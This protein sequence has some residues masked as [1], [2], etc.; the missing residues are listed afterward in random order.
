MQL[1]L[2]PARGGGVRGGR[3]GRTPAEG[4]RQ[5]SNALQRDSPPPPEPR[6]SAPSWQE[7]KLEALESITDNNT[8][9]LQKLESYIQENVCVA[10]EQLQKKT[11]HTQ[12]AAMLEISTNL[13]SHSTEQSR[14][15][16]DVETQVLNHTSRLEVQLLEYSLST[17]RLEKLFL[18]QANELA[19][20]NDRNRLLEQ[21]LAVMEAGHAEELRVAQQEKRQLQA[22]LDKHS[23]LDM[24]VVPRDEPLVSRD[25]AEIYK[26]GV[27]QSGVYTIRLPNTTHTLKRAG[28]SCGWSGE[29]HADPGE[30]Y[31]RRPHQRR[32]WV[33]SEWHRDPGAD[34]SSRAHQRRLWVEREGHRDPGADWS[35]QAH[36]RRLWV[37]R[38]GHRDPGA[39]WTSQAHQRTRWYERRGA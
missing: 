9:W 29:G 26:S 14:K 24:S 3:G 15:L 20:L 31:S 28:K 23:T 12:T 22:L 34:W 7:R 39:D 32:L 25:C 10:L 6:Q 27:T 38:E 17:S 11:L 18:L 5:V 37:E 8:Q 16:M 36:Q 1:H 13:L 35:S 19:R 33:E 2:H 21:R 30:D 4:K